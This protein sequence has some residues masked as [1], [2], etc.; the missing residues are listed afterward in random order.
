M[1]LEDNP[2]FANHCSSFT[3]DQLLSLNL[4]HGL[5]A[6]VCCLFSC[7]IILLLLISKSYRT[8]LQRM[9]LYLMIATVLSELTLAATIEHQYY[10]PQQDE[11]CFWVGYLSNWAAMLNAVFTIGV[12]IYLFFLVWYLAKGNTV[13]HFSQS[14][15]QRVALEVA[16]LVLSPALTFVYASGP[17]FMKQYG[18]AGAL[19]WIQALDKH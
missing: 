9:L 16:Y 18:L 4:C 3:S 13:P 5:N 14:R 10:Y 7:V 8:V 6:A 11:V 19:C 2:Q 12:M 1:T 17:H 15:C